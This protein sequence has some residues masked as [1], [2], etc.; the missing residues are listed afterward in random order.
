MH[1]QITVRQPYAGEEIAS[2]RTQQPLSARMIRDKGHTDDNAAGL[3]EITRS[4]RGN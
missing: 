1:R 2:H 3:L 4:R